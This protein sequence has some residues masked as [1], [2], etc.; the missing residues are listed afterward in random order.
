MSRGVFITGTDTGVGKTFVTAAL[1]RALIADGVAARALKPVA[2]GCRLT[3][4]GWRNDDAEALIAAMGDAA[5]AYDAVNPIALG[6]AIAPHLAARSQGFEI[7]L[8]PIEAAFARAAHTADLVLV[9]GAGGWA[10]PLSPTRMQSDIPRALGLPVLLV[11]GI[12]L[13][14]INHALLSARAIAGDGLP[15][16]GWIANT[17]DDGLPRADE[18]IETIAEALDAPLAVLPRDPDPIQLPRLLAAATA[19]LRTSAAAPAIAEVAA[20]EARRD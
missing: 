15:L 2:S 20:R 8:A 18:A 5:P 16:V 9:E 10:I 4:A 19:R 6:E 7:T 17:L 3:A 11:V 14:A 13:G 12:R 1:I